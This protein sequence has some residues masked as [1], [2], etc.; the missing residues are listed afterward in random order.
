MTHTAEILGLQQPSQ[1]SALAIT[2]GASVFDYV[3]PG[4]GI[5]ILTGGT[6]SAISIG[7]NAVFTATGLIV[8]IFPVSRKD[9]VRVTY[10]ALPTMTFIKS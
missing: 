9:T 3:A 4:N 2:V 8:G 5:V 6:V 10:T 1:N 7:R